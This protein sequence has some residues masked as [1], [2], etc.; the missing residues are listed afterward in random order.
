MQGTPMETS[1]FFFDQGYFL[2][3]GTALRLRL[4]SGF[5]FAQP[6]RSSGLSFLKKPGLGPG[7]L[8]LVSYIFKSSHFHI[9]KSLFYGGEIEACFEELGIKLTRPEC[10]IIHQ[11]KMERNGRLQP[12]DHELTQRAFHSCNHFFARLTRCYQLRNHRVIVRGDCISG[13][14]V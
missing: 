4:R 10:R 2:S 9:F 6:D 13:I 11:C 8:L 14:D 12:F 5:D 3:A 1:G 7:L